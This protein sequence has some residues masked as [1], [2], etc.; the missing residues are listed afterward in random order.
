MMMMMMMMVVV[1]VMAQM[2][3]PS[4]KQFISPPRPLLAVP[5]IS[6]YLGNDNDKNGMRIGNRTKAFEWYHFE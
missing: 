6:L 5:N 3:C 4:T 1:M 2:A